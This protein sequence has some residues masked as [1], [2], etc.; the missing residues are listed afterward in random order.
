MANG[1][2]PLPEIPPEQRTPLVEALLAVI[3]AQQDR[4][5]KLEETVQQLRDEIAILKGQKP[6]PTIAPSRLE[7]P[8]PE[9]PPA[10]GQKRPGST[11]KPKNAQLTITRERRIDYPD[12][13]AGSV[14]KGYEEFVV[15]E[16]DLRVTVTRYWR[17]RVQTPDGQTL[18]APLPP[19][20]RPGRHFGPGL[21]AFVLHQHHHNGVTQPLLLEQLRQFGQ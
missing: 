16:L 19:D 17:Q 4:I 18:L 13:P 15:Q 20:L 11:K 3:C 5:A 7:Q 6:R 12:P 10:D 1:L 14:S 21:V 9:A 8:A 2:V